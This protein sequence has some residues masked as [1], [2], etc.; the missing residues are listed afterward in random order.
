MSEKQRFSKAYTRMGLF[1]QQIENHK[2][3]GKSQV[4]KSWKKSYVG[5]LN[6]FK[7][8]LKRLKLFHNEPFKIQNST[9][10]KRRICRYI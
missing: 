3:Y 8:A 2:Y 5:F 7:V 4:R 6:N 10:N 1:S 9:S